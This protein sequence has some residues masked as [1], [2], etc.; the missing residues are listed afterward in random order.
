M[1]ESTKERTNHANRSGSVPLSS[2][3]NSILPDLCCLLDDLN[4]EAPLLPRGERKE[5]T[6]ERKKKERK[7]GRKQGRKEINRERED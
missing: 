2:V 6:K 1:K 7:K 5:K 3:L 4:G